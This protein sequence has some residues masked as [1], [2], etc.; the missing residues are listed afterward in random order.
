MKG[1]G[2]FETGLLGL[3]NADLVLEYLGTDSIEALKR[4]IEKNRG[5]LES[6]D[7]CHNLVHGD[8]RPDNILV[9]G[10]AITGIIDWEFAHSGCSYMDIGNLLRHV[11][12]EW[13]QDLSIGLLEAGFKLP[14]DWRFR[15]LLIDLASH[16]EF[17]TSNRSEQFKR[18]CVSR[19]EA[20]MKL[21]I[22]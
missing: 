18:E 15:S 5:I 10:D 17:L 6:F 13:E 7:C 3:L 8:F 20:F 11:S 4:M 16:L 1:W 2:S 22:A 19:I 12:S 21:C 9:S 14:P